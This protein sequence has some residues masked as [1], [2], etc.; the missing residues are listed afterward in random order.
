MWFLLLAL[1]AQSTN[2][3]AE[4]N[5]ALDAKQYDRAIELFTKA[6]AADP[7]DYG[8]EFQLALTYSLLGKDPDAIPHYRAALA[9]RP[10]LYEAE[11]NLGLSLLR[12]KDA[13]AAIPHLKAA[14]DQKPQEFRPAYYFAQALLDTKQYPAAETAF[15]NAAALDTRS[16]AAQ[17][18]WAEALLRQGRAD[19]AKPHVDDA[20]TLDRTFRHQYVELAE[21]YE[22]NHRNAEAIAMY[23]EFPD[24][25]IAQ[26][27][28]GV[29]LTAEGD[30]AEAIRS[31]ELAVAKSPTEA[32]RVALAQAYAKNKQLDKAQAVAA[33]AVEASPRDPDLRLFYARFLRDQRKFPEAAAQFAAV[34]Q[35]KPD[36]I[37]AWSE[38]ASILVITGQ[39]PQ[40]IAA[41]DRV[42]ALGAE[43]S[44]H[45]FF[46][47]LALDHLEQRAEA[48]QNYNKFLA[49]SQGKFPDQEFQARQ[50]VRILEGELKKKR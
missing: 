30:L 13:A 49:G 46:R 36:S 44:G 23:R 1:L 41:L 40:A 8:A 27:H 7:K 47:A 16:G 39:Y 25:P 24:D 32:N 35:I 38:L 45:V 14:V 4:G 17:S 2:Y 42:R 18:G 33:E 10:G 20:F 9:L 48:I 26:E 43:N 29:L 31:L 15:R 3:L 6:V 37:E 12:T 22:A 19:D 28:L 5:Q 34:A 11:L 21:L 50:R